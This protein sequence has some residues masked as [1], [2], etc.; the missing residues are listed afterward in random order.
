M[1]RIKEILKERGITYK[2]MAARLGTSDIAL[3]ASLRGNPTM[4]TLE[5]VAEVLCVEVPELFK[6]REGVKILPVLRSHDR[7]TSPKGRKRGVTSTIT[8]NQ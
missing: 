6:P 7:H 1:L 8:T 2:E 5:K 3:R 4:K